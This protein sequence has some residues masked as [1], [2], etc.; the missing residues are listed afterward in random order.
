[1]NR[2]PIYITAEDHIKLTALLT[3][4]VALLISSPDLLAELQA[5]LDHAQ[6]V[7]PEEV[8]EDL[9][10]MDSTIT[11]RDLDTLETE[12]YTLV[13]PERANIAED[14]LSV[15]APIGT[16]VLG[17]RVGDEVRWQVP[18]G[19]R[20]LRIEQVLYQ[21]ERQAASDQRHR[22]RETASIQS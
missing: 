4:R 9:V 21:P 6:I 20:R 2:S 15:L 17:Y 3:S 5:E 14:R 12:T 16:A 19:W 1:M 10:T 7:S 11:L 22:E 13:Y 18:E 8:P